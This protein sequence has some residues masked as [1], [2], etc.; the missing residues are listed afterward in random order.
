[1][2]S[3]FRSTLVVCAVAM[4]FAAVTAASASATVSGPEWLVKGTPLAAG[5]TQAVK[6]TGVGGVQ[7]NQTAASWS[8]TSESGTGELIGGIPGTG[9]GTII[10]KGC[11]LSGHSVES[12]AL[13]T[14]ASVEHKMVLGEITFA[15]KTVLVYPQGTEGEALEA[16]VP[17]GIKGEANTFTKVTA[18]GSGCG[19]SING[20]TG[21]FSANGTEIK[22]PAFD[23][24]CGL[25]AKVG[26]IKAGAFA[27]L[28]SG[29]Q[30]TEGG[31][32]LPLTAI[33]TGE[34]YSPATKTLKE[35]KC[36]SELTIIGAGVNVSGLLKVETSPTAELFGWQV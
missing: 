26:Q 27:T 15:Y 10:L 8:C 31:L 29:G 20:H 2:R 9:T 30:A 21:T 22:E 34:L 35:I 12:C 4:A 33:T 14:S 19:E 11:S 5:K 6:S 17:A 24:H 18:S 36:E 1:M 13:S 23:K 16:I 3:M 28:A 7:F 32:S 25:L